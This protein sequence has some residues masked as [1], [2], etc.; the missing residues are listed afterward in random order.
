[1]AG[2]YLDFPFSTGLWTRNETM[3]V[4]MNLTVDV[5]NH[6]FVLEAYSDVLK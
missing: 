1:M 4:L 2:L 6:I 5:R 3:F